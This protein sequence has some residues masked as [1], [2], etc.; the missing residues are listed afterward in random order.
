MADLDKLLIHKLYTTMAGNFEKLNLGL[1]KKV[2]GHFGDKETRARTSG[3]P[4]GSPDVKSGEV[5]GRV[6]GVEGAAKHRVED[7]VDSS[8]TTKLLGRDLGGGTVDRGDEG[9]GEAGHLLK[10]QG[11]T[12]LLAA[13][14]HVAIAGKLLLGLAHESVE[15]RLDIRESLSD[16]GHEGGVESFGEV[17]C[18]ASGRD[19]SIGGMVLEEVGLVLERVLHWLA[20]LDILLR[21]VDD[22][23]E[24]KLKRV[25]TAR[26]DVERIGAMVHQVDLGKNTDSPPA[27]R[28]DMAGKLESF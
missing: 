17:L 22:T 25:N 9:V 14:V 4:D 23:D 10:D 13:E 6:D 20:T 8:T 3:V 11:A 21:T 28:V 18:A 26:E 7:E 15:A 19:V 24:S 5:R 2:E 1:D 27:E 16:V 12:V